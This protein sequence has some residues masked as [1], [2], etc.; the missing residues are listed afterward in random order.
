MKCVTCPRQSASMRLLA[1]RNYGLVGG[2]LV[3]TIVLCDNC[4]LTRDVL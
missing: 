3:Q 2:Y 1:V 4:A